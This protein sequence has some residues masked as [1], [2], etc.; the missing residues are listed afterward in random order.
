MGFNDDLAGEAT[1]ISNRLQ[2]L[3]TQIHPMGTGTGPARAAASPAMILRGL[4]W[5]SPF[6]PRIRR[7]PSPNRVRCLVTVRRLI[8]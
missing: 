8:T 7:L 6:G 2:A 5:F 4:R 1:R 3:L